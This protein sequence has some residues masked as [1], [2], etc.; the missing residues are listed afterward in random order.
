MGLILVFLKEFESTFKERSHVAATHHHVCSSSKCFNL[1]FYSGRNRK[2]RLWRNKEF[3]IILGIYLSVLSHTELLL[4]VTA[5]ISV[6]SRL[7]T[8]YG[9]QTVSKTSLVIK[10]EPKVHDALYP[11][12]AFSLF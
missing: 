9:Q 10:R 11:H 5:N 8:A 2:E 7:L 4:V 1:C 12:A 6:G 3:F